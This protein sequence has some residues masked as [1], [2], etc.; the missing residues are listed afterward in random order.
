MDEEKKPSEE[1]APPPLGIVV[2]ENLGF[3]DEGGKENAKEQKN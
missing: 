2:Q 1:E 3:S